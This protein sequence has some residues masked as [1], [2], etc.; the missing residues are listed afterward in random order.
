MSAPTGEV[1]DLSASELVALYRARRLSPV[2]AV[3][4]AVA[5]FLRDIASATSSPDRPYFW[6]TIDRVLR[7][8]IEHDT[9]HPY[10]VVK[11]RPRRRLFLRFR[12]NRSGTSVLKS[13]A[14]GSGEGH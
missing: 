14:L 2:E 11:R 4:A 9:C 10:A 7:K 8:T 13:R 12:S 1:A 5:R 6:I 3:G